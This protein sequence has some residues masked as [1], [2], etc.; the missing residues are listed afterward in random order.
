MEKIIAHRGIFDNQRVI[1]NTI[2]AFSLAVE[3]NTPFELDV[4]LT[5]D[6]QLVVFHDETL[7]RLGKFNLNVQKSNYS[8]LK[9]INLMNV[10]EHIP[11]F[12]EVLELNNDKVKMLIEIKKTKRIKETVD[13]TI[14]ELKPYMNYIIE[15][16]DPR[17]VKYIHKNYS[18]IRCGLLVENKYP[19]RI[20]N[21]FLKTS[22]PIKYCK[23]DFISISKKLLNNKKYMKK[24][25]KLPKYIW[26]ITESNE[27]NLEND[28][29]YICNNLLDK[30][31]KKHLK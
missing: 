3:R 12:K 18:W 26:T 13:Q 21:L 19:K 6:N 7:R 25:K 22:L 16:F 11:L 9:N 30:N 5:K 2:E 15:S 1:E 8:D 28:Y 24:I 29:T 10:D 20:E 17:I 23:P 31:Y 14:E 27:I 4:Q